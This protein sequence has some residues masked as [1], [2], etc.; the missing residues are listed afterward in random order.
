MRVFDWLKWIDDSIH[1]ADGIFS[2][3]QQLLNKL[4]PLLTKGDDNG[5]E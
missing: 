4:K 3:L 1:D 5:V 2:F